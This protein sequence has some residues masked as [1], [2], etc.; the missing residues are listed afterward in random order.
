M[1]LPHIHRVAH[2]DERGE[3]TLEFCRCGRCRSIVRSDGW[4]SVGRWTAS[5]GRR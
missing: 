2:R 4:L 3:A 5:A 1:K